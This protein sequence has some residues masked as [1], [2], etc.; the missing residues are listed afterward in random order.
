MTV[1]LASIAAKLGFKVSMKKCRHMRMNH[2]SDVPI[3]LHEKVGEEVK[4]K[5]STS[6]GTLA[7]R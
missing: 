3:I 2:H 5:K 4:K 7:P 6:S 1:D